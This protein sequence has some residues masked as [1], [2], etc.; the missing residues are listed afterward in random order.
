[1][2]RPD[3]RKTDLE[4]PAGWPPPIPRRRAACRSEA[5]AGRFLTGFWWFAAVVMIAV[6]FAPPAGWPFLRF[7]PPGRA[8]A[9]SRE[10]GHR[11]EGPGLRS[12]GPERP[13]IPFERLQGE[14]AGPDHLQRDLVHLLQGGDPPFQID[15]CRPMRSRGWRS[16]T[17]TSR[18]RR[19]RW[20]NSPPNTGFPTACSWTKT[21][22][23]RHIRYPGRSIDGPRGPKR[24][25]PLPPVPAGGAAH[26]DAP[27]EMTGDIRR[28]NNGAV[29]QAGRIDA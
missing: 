18:N 1:M 23:W 17:S 3:I 10:D 29:A 9:C 20:P 5:A 16:S 6:G 25:H 4:L 24:E 7:Q 22:P 12:Q 14:T 21:A 28:E 13:E 19:R 15:P 27:E 26:R 2:F 8:A 11:R